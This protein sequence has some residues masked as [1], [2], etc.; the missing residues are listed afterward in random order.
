M[1]TPLE[2]L[3]RL[4][5]KSYWAEDYLDD[6]HAA[7]VTSTWLT[8]PL[9]WEDSQA[10]ANCLDAISDLD[11]TDNAPFAAVWALRSTGALAPVDHVDVE[12]LVWR[13]EIEDA[14]YDSEPLALPAFIPGIGERI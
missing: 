14:H 5:P 9:S 4:S 10:L 3:Q 6:I 7:L 11:L 1:S 12:L 8:R 2:I 13:M